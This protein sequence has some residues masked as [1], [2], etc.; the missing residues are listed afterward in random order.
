MESTLTVAKR[1]LD[2]LAAGDFGAV[3]TLFTDTVAWHQPG[4]NQ[5]SGT[6]VGGAAVNQ[7]LGG[8]MA[9]TG[10]TL[11]VKP[12]GAVMVNGALFTLPVHFT[13]KHGGAEV[14][15]DGVD[16]FRV[17]GDLIAEI[18]LFSADQPAEDSFWDA[19]RSDR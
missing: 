14:A 10:G 3:A 16:V 17:E 12:T 19:E 8:Q 7:L 13:A 15:M 6:H 5:F 2:A 9:F 11:E 4:G 1:Y 18:W